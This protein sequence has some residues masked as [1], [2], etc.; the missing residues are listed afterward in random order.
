[1]RN[2]ASSSAP[3]YTVTIPAD[4]TPEEQA[5]FDATGQRPVRVAVPETAAADTA[6]EMARQLAARQRTNLAS[7]V[8]DG[9]RYMTPREYALYRRV[10]L[11]KVRDW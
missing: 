7:P 9:S 4:L 10:S 8:S 3:L 6:I 5:R 1:M 2:S 11:T